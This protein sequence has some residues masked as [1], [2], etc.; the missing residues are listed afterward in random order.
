MAR[1]RGY[2]TGIPPFR[3]G[4]IALISIALITYFVF[5]RDN[6]FSHPFELKAVFQNSSN[7]APRSP[8][9]V[10]GIAV[11][12]VVGVTPLPNGTSKVR[13]QLQKRALPIHADAR[14]KIRPRIFLGGNFVVD[15]FAGSPSAPVLHDGDTIPLTQTAAPVQLGDVIS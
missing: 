3:A 2:Q 8:V 9:R 4:V 6:P 7:L 1:R 11:G 14:L 10:A 12:K 13:M 15:L 5:S